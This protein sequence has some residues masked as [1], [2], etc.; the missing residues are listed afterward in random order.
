MKVARKARRFAREAVTVYQSE[1][2]M[3]NIE[4]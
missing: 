4:R 3:K 1:G 2:A